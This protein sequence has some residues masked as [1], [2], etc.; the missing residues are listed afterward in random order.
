MSERE[1]LA[2]FTPC[3]DLCY[4]P[5]VNFTLVGSH[6]EIIV[7]SPRDGTACGSSSMISL[8]RAKVLEILEEAI[9]KLRAFT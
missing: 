6:V 9:T 5:Y 7:R 4:P 1:C 8:P 2:A 3:D